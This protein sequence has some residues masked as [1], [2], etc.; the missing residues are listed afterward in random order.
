MSDLIIGRLC[1]GSYLITH[2]DI[3]VHSLG[4]IG[5]I[6]IDSV[7]VK[8]GIGLKYTKAVQ[9]STYALIPPPKKKPLKLLLK[10]DDKYLLS[11]ISSC[12]YDKVYNTQYT[13]HKIYILLKELEVISDIDNENKT[14]FT[15]RKKKPQNLR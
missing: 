7:R 10:F 3:V 6:H 9:L 2:K 13:L 11:I 1:L 15:G 14:Y 12:F 8:D 4:V 5:L